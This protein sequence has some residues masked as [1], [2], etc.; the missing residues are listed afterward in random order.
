MTL[1]AFNKVSKA[2]RW[3]VN[4]ATGAERIPLD[5]Q[6]EYWITLFATKNPLCELENALILFQ[7]STKVALTPL[8]CMDV[9]S[10][11]S[12]TLKIEIYKRASS[13]CL[14]ILHEI[15]ESTL[16]LSHGPCLRA[17]NLHEQW[18]LALG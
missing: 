6:R 13:K 17:A 14:K 8:T 18:R 10:C 2:T 9:L 5:F 1:L 16:W 4:V 11:I 3:N 12:H 7:L 15:L